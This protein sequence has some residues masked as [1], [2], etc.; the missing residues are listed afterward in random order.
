MIPRILASSRFFVAF[1]ALGAFASAVALLVYGVLAVARTVWAAFTAC[2]FSLDGA[3][4]LAVEL[5][6]L[7][8]LF[9][10]GTVLYIVALGLYELF[11]DP[12]LP[13]PPWLRIASLDDLKAK[14][15]QVV[16]VLLG[17]SFLGSVVEWNGDE[18]IIE[19]GAAVAVVIAAFGLILFV[20]KLPT[21][22]GNGPSKQE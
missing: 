12:D 19:L 6:Q 11:V 18:A 17:V 9:L 2:G 4:R 10:L 8:D 22:G 7:T 3:K 13:V 5:I 16:V 15:I 21:K 1:A 20:G 14:L